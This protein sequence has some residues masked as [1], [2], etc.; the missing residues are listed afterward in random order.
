M[1]KRPIWRDST[2]SSATTHNCADQNFGDLQEDIALFSI[3][4]TS[5]VP[6]EC[7]SQASL[8]LCKAYGMML[9]IRGAVH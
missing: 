6:P 8:G 9:D 1:Y 3:R 4:R 7:G 5:D 2:D